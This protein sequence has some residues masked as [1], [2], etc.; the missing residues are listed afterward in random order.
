MVWDILTFNRFV[1]QDILI[2]FYYMGVFTIPITLFILREYVS[3]KVKWLKDSDRNL[4]T[5]MLFFIL[6]FCMELC[7]RMF[8]E[9]MIGYFDMH[10]YLYAI[11]QK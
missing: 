2:F 1:T 11:S 10:D 9:F 8:F 6:F 4:K 3:K 5:L 7:L